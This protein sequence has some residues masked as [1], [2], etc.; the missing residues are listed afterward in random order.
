MRTNKIL[1][2]SDLHCGHRYGL[3]HPSQ[4]INKIQLNAWKFFEQGIKKYGPFDTIFCNGDLIDGRGKKNAGVELIT[5]NL[6]EQADMAINIIKQIQQLNHHKKIKNIYFTRGTPYH[7]GEA[8]DWENLVAREFRN[9]NKVNIGETLLIDVNGV[10][11]D[12]KHKVASGSLPHT[13]SSSP[14][15]DIVFAI[16]KEGLEGRAKAD[17][18]IRSHVHYYNFV[19][20]MQRIAVTT[21]ALQIN[22][23][24]GERQCNGIVNFGFLVC[25]VQEN[26][27]LK[28]TKHISQIPFKKEQIIKI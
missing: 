25:E 8:E 9:G 22:S 20:C 24:Y 23:S 15:R 14:S 28:W 12:L 4:C 7:T 11:F 26:K 21:P 27:Q 18:F 3:A 5:T 19:E 2:L 17:V 10:V 1:I 6:E 16:L 13:R